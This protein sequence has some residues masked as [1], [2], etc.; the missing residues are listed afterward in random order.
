MNNYGY[1][2]IQL[3]AYVGILLA[4]T[5]PIGMYLVQVLD[6]RGKTFLD[7]I[8]HPVE[9]LIYRLF[10]LDPDKEQNWR[11]YSLSLLVF[12]MIGFLMTY[13]ILRLQHHLPLNPQGF[14]PLS[15][16][17]AFNTAVSFTTNTN[18]QSYAGESTMSYFSQMVGLA[19]HNFTSA[20]TGIAV[21]AALVRGIARHTATVIGNF[22]VDIVRVPISISSCPC[23]WCTRY[24]SF[25]KA[26]SR[27]SRPMIRSIWWTRHLF[28]HPSRTHQGG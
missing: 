15:P 9:I 25:L 7:P 19:F 4:L 13:G 21:A 20:A 3:A 28:R 5:K 6:A 22:W 18:W 17:L 8:M 14:G 23:A 16:H 1:G 12:S 27:I 10:G 2:W 24:F 11:E 26:R